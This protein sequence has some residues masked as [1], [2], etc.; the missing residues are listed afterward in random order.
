[1]AKD[2]KKIKSFSALAKELSKTAPRP[3]PAVAE[4]PKEIVELGEGESG[5]RALIKT[6]TGINGEELAE[7]ATKIL[8]GEIEVQKTTKVKK[9]RPKAEGW[10]PPLHEKKVEIMGPSITERMDALRFLTEY[11]IGRPKQQVEHTGKDGGPI[12]VQAQDLSKLSLEE[13]R[14]LDAVHEK[15]VGSG[16]TANQAAR[17]ALAEGGVGGQEPPAASRASE[18]VVDVTPKDPA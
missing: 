8:R 9:W 11:S 18:A 1:M 15:L 12:R 17:G 4:T 3:P 7:F 2:L 16:S 5:F 13:L 10:V 6:K 14:T